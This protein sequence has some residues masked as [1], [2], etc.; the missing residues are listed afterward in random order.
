MSLK[1]NEKNY[2][3]IELDGR[4][5]I[6]IQEDHCKHD[7]QFAAKARQEINDNP[8]HVTR[9]MEEVRR[10][11]GADE[12]FNL[13]FHEDWYVTT[14]LRAGANDPQETYQILADT[15]Y[16]K[17]TNCDY[18]GSVAS[19]RHVF[20]EGLVWL[21]PER[22]EDG[23][24]V[25]VVESGKKWNPSKVS[26][27]ELNTACNALISAL[28]QSEEVQIHG[29]K[30]ISDV[31]GLSMTQIMQF[32][33]QATKIMLDQLDKCSPVRLRHVHTVNNGMV[34]NVLFSIMKPIMSKRMRAKMM[35]HGRNWTELGKYI[36]LKVLPPRFGGT[37]K[38]PA[39]DGRLLGDL[40]MHYDEWMK[41][42]HG[43]G[44]KR[45]YYSKGAQ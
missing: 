2:P 3:Y 29:Y 10:L 26:L 44:F 22:D 32:T 42:M 14:Y 16:Q 34:Y 43:F 9:A 7:E 1:Y 4:Y 38:A 45:K 39:Y 13:P 24:A 15:G 17:S 19:I 18:F 35:I 37:S 5:Q 30:M 28:M 20:D 8:E 27:V 33:P 40:M 11:V 6:C 21:L 25:V 36:S 41:R 23:S 12:R 31:E